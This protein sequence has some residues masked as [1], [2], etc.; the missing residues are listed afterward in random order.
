[1]KGTV[2]ILGIYNYDNSVFDLFGLPEGA[3]AETAK[4]LIFA[5]CAELELLYPEPKVLRRLIGKWSIAHQYK[6]KHLWNTLNLEY[7]PID[8]YS[9]TENEKT[10]NSNTGT[11]TDE[12]S[13]DGTRKTNGIRT[14]VYDVAAYNESD[15]KTA[16]KTTETYEPTVTDNF[17][18][19]NTQTRDLNTDTTRNLTR[20]GNIG[21]TTSQ[22][23]IQMEREISNFNFYEEVVRD[24]KNMFCL[25]V[26]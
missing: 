3:D 16:N 22:R 17:S 19:K 25:E 21:V 7:N 15:V 8:N 12:G 24:F 9:M 1:M 11:V 4:D 2:S 13:N 5:E 6:W 10:V 26:Y 18:D 14:S 20:S 23:M